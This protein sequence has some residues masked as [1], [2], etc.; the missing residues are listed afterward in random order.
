MDIFKNRLAELLDYNAGGNSHITATISDNGDILSVSM[1]VE[2]DGESVTLNT[3]EYLIEWM[4]DIGRVIM[5]PN[6]VSDNWN[7]YY[8]YTVHGRCKE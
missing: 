7:K 4:D 3:R 6:F 2:I 8:L 5:W 1:I